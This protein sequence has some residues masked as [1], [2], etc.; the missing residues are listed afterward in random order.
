MRE[1]EH[2]LNNVKKSYFAFVHAIVKYANKKP[3]RYNAVMDFLDEYPDAEPS[4]IIE[5]VSNQKD[6]FEDDVRNKDAKGVL[7]V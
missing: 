2:R 3:E 5:F 6:F 4:D 1:L 7:T